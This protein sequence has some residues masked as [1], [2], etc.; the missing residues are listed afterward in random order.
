MQLV[1]LVLLARVLLIAVGLLSYDLASY[2]LYS[3]WNRD[4]RVRA[5][6]VTVAPDV[7]GYECPA[8]EAT[9]TSLPN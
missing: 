4:A 8:S 3:P 6:A 9:R 5:N 1:V 2:Y 7:S